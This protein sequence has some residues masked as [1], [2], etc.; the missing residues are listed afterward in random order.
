MTT[1]QTELYLGWTN[2]ETWATHLWITNDEG[3]YTTLRD[4]ANGDEPVWE[5]ADELYKL[6]EERNPLAD[7]ANIYSDLL[8]YALSRVNWEEIIENSMD[9]LDSEFHGG[10]E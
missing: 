3:V 5:K 2:R 9:L 4:I 8:S 6:M 10:E 7:E 1:T